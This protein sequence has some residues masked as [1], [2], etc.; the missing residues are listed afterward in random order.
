MQR[1]ANRSSRGLEAKLGFRIA[2]CKRHANVKRKVYGLA[3]MHMK[4]SNRE[5][6]T[7]TLRV[8]DRL[9]FPEHTSKV[10]NI[11]I[12][13]YLVFCMRADNI[14]PPTRPIDPPWQPWSTIIQI[15][16]RMINYNCGRYRARWSHYRIVYR[17]SAN[18]TRIPYQPDM[19]MIIDVRSYA[20]VYLRRV[21][22]SDL[23]R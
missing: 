9:K 13:I 20:T 5:Y 10:L 19:S 8:F 21:P 2:S 1:Y 3:F 12:F 7:L 15:P 17:I 23:M 6:I 14:F 22:R 18:L 11:D 16:S 4:S